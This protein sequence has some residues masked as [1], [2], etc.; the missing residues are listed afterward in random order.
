MKTACISAASAVLLLSCVAS[1]QSL[2]RSPPREVV[3]ENGIADPQAPLRAYSL[4]L[5]EAPRPRTFQVHDKITIIISQSSSQS[6]KEKT[7]LKKDASLK[8]GVRQFPD[9]MALLDGRIET[10]NGSPIVGVDGSG[11]TKWKGDGT[12]ERSDRFTDRITATIIDVK[13]NGVLMLEAKRTVE[14]NQEKQ[15]LVLSGEVRREDVTAQN[16]VQSSQLADLALIVKNEGQVAENAQKGWIT[17][18]F[19]AVFSF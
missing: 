12:Y 16:T 13:P 15:I 2:L 5:V 9:L 6:A 18:L 3:D 4:L 11:S 7:D 19:D 1:A 17:N 14:K 8:A 10:D